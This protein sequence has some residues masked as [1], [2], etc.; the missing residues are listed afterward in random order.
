MDI[1]DHYLWL[2]AG[3]VFLA[4]EAFGMHGIGMFFAGLA[5]VLVG[6]LL[7]FGLIGQ[8]DYLLQ[9]SIWFG[10]TCLFAILLWKPMKRWR[11]SSPENGDYKNMLGSTATICDGPLEK[12][13]QGKAHWSGTKMNAILSPDAAIASLAEGEEATVTAVKGNCLTLSPKE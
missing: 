11:I 3:A 5:A 4:L 13:K 6:G 2:I 12:G 10:T 7:E 1:S 9:F 8:A